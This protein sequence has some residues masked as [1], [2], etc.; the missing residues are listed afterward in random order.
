MSD[1][2]IDNQVHQRGSA[3]ILSVMMMMGLGLLALN[4]LNQ[5]LNS[6]LALTGQEH[7]YL[8]A[9]Q[10]AA[11][12]LSWG[13]SQ[14]WLLS[15][16]PTWQCQ[17]LTT[18][19]AADRPLRSCVR[20]SHRPGIFILK[21]EGQGLEGEAPLVLYQLASHNKQARGSA[22]FTPLKGGWVD[23]CPLPTPR[24]CDE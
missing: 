19:P 24:G 11:S 5:H 3:M 7:R 16:S 4:T 1:K 13:A 8:Q 22:I 18:G 10:Q 6:A 17:S 12:S 9:W 21:G 20:P 2:A 23:F 14:R 15:T